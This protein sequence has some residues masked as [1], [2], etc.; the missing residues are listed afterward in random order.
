MKPSAHSLARAFATQLHADIG[1]DISTVVAL[2]AQEGNSPCC[3]SHDFC[4]ANQT[5]LDAWQALTGEECEF[6]ADDDALTALINEAWNIAKAHDFSRATLLALELYHAGHRITKTGML[7]D[8]AKRLVPAEIQATTSP[9]VN[10]AI[11]ARAVHMVNI[12][13]LD[14]SKVGIYDK[15]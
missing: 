7:E 3:H 4:D 15:L 1:N 10:G 8:P 12:W 11:V 14:A 13:S 9:A 6:S 5:M 2:N